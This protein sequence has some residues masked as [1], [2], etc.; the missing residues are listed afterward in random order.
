MSKKK[1]KYLLLGAILGFLAGIFLAPKKGSEMRKE[2]KDK[3]NDIKEDPK[4]VLQGTY[5]N[6]KQ[7]INDIIDDAE[8]DDNIY[9]QEDE[10]V[11]SKTFDDEGEF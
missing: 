2:A 3:I 5:D 11:I 1:G 4:E 10:I 9:I 8:S 7:K 6:V